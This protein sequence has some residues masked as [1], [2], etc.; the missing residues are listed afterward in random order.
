MVYCVRNTEGIEK[1]MLVDNHTHTRFSPDS[2]SDPEAMI[3]QAIALGL[4][5]ITITDHCDPC[6]PEGL[7]GLTDTRAYVAC[8]ETLQRKYAADITVGIGLEIAYLP[9]GVP[10]AAALATSEGI[11]YVIDSVHVCSGSDCYY[12]HHFDGLSREQAYGDYFRAVRESLDVPYPFHAVG[13]IGYIERKAPYPD[14]HITYAGYREY[15]DPIFDAMIERD[16][17]LEMNTNA[18][19]SLFSLPSPDLVAAYYARGG[20]LVT[21]SSDAH[22]PERIAERFSEA[23]RILRDIGFTYLS[24]VEKGKLVTYRL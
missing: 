23:E 13:H 18:A 5:R 4:K 8:L 17:I 14:R 9:E 19:A 15:L 3:R 10:A 12:P 6:H 24:A 20:R 1:V 21:L 2:Q 7:F 11:E 16:K 22:T